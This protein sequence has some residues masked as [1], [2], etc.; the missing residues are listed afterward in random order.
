MRGRVLQA[1]S[2]CTLLLPATWNAAAQTVPPPGTL[3]SGGGASAPGDRGT[4]P[5]E[6]PVTDAAKA[7]DQNRLQPLPSGVLLVPGAVASSTDR[8]T[9][10]PEANRIAGETYH[11]DYF[12][13]TF[14]LPAG[15]TQRYEGP[16]PSD[17]GAYVLAELV[18]A[19][20]YQGQSKGTIVITAQD[21][22]FSLRPAG[23][24]LSIVKDASDR[25]ESFY[26][27]EHA[28]YAL[29]I[30][31][32]P[33]ARFDYRSPAA[34]LHWYVLTTEIRCHAVQFVFTSRDV[35]LLD[36][37]VQTVTALQLSESDAHAAVCIANYATA[38]NLTY[39]VQPVLA[40]GR[41]NPIPVR[42][43]IDKSGRVRHA[44]VISAFADQA[45][46]VTEAVTQWRFKPYLR[47]G[48]AVEVETGVMFGSAAGSRVP[49]PTTSASPD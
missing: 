36:S 41:F 2:L 1:L 27:V 11:N 18:P 34:Q 8:V 40:D 12:G 39:S 20:K 35:A 46:I 6:T 44:H 3:L 24:A 31:S 4:P 9:A 48:E 37:L 21:L 30:N 45:R 47:N 49:R 28:P 26:E 10:V 22:F 42:I 15:W 29:T 13:L 38:A 16:P 5:A 43:T 32:H 23:D 17:S 7:D 19:D 33:F 25:L 14:R